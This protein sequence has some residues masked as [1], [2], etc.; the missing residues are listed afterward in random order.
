[1]WFTPASTAR[2]STATAASRSF[3]GAHHARPGA[4]ASPRSRRG[5]P[6]S[7]RGRRCRRARRP[8]SCPARYA[9][10]VGTLPEGRTRGADA[11]RM[12]SVSRET[13]EE[14]E[15]RLQGVIGLA[16]LR[17]L[18]G[19]WR[20]VESADPPALDDQVLAVVRD[21][22]GWSALRPAPEEQNEE[23]RFGVF[24][25]HS[26]RRRRHQRVRRLAGVVAEAAAGYR[27]LRRLRQ[28]P[29]TRRRL[30]LLGRAG[31]HSSTTRSRPCTD[32]PWTTTRHR[33][34]CGAH[35]PPVL[36]DPCRDPFGNLVRRRHEAI[37][38][39][40]TP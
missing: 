4:A 37:P 28:Q 20:F 5:A 32:S 23:E 26:S 30:R 6:R 39:E 15:S 25:F 35:G 10:I 19:A 33:A 29:A 14:T 18:P 21:E 8:S 38:S 11:A 16:E 2:R 36:E 12:V 40:R 13:A 17:V 22:D 7:R 31:R 1:M 9:R 24:S 27:R 3:G 34:S